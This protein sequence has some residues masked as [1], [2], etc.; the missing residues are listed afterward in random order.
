MLLLTGTRAVR[1]RANNLTEELDAVIPHV[2]IW[3]GAVGQ[4]AVLP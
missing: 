1:A 2:Q 3:M 4:L